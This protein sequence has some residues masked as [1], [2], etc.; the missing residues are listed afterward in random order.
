[1]LLQSIK[2]NYAALYPTLM[3]RGSQPACP[4]LFPYEQPCPTWPEGYF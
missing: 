2:D 4:Q 3:F 1:M